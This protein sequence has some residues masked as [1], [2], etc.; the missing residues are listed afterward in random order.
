MFTNVKTH[1]NSCSTDP[2]TEA[3]VSPH[4]GTL[5]LRVGQLC[6][7][8]NVPCGHICLGIIVRG[9]MVLGTTAVPRHEC[10]GGHF[11]GGEGG[12]TM[13]TTPVNVYV[14]LHLH[15]FVNILLLIHLSAQL[16]HGHC[17]CHVARPLNL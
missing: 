4:R 5:V 9:T 6:L 14:G 11:A 12:G 10:P 3:P 2:T 13:P 16:V 17:G 8:M 7:G 15:N 1:G